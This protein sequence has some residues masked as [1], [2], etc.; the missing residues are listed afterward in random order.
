MTPNFWFDENQC[1]SHFGQQPTSAASW[2][3]N[4]NLSSNLVQNNR[5]F[6]H[7]LHDLK[8]NI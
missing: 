8:S 1:I 5:N 3:T 2:M 4:A 7:I 6:D